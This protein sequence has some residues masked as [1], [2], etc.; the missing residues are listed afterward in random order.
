VGLRAHYQRHKG[1]RLPVRN[2][3]GSIQSATTRNAWSALSQEAGIGEDALSEHCRIDAAVGSPSSMV[4]S[5]CR[6]APPAMRWPYTAQAVRWGAATDGFRL[7]HVGLAGECTPESTVAK[8]RL[9]FLSV[10]TPHG[11]QPGSAASPCGPPV[12]ASR[13]PQVASAVRP[14][15]PPGQRPWPGARA[16]AVR[17]A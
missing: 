11:L 4:A 13:L 2:Y 10:H 5:L 12:R 8:W 7:A 1:L 17:W 16:T 15:S 14:Q 3:N 6:A 9:H